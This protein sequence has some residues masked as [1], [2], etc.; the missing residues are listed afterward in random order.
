MQYITMGDKSSPAVLLIHGMLCTGKDNLGFGRYLSD[1]F[2]VISPTL[3]GHGNDGTD[4][5]CVEEEAAKI[6]A[7]LRSEGITSLALI[8]GSSM[9]AE[10]AL[11]VRDRCRKEGIAVGRCFFDGGPFFCFHPIKRYF[12]RLTFRRLVKILNDDPDRAYDRLTKNRLVKFITKD[13][14]SQFEPMLRSI[15]SER[16]TFTNRTVDGMVKVCYD[17]AL[18]DFTEEEQRSMVFFFSLDEPARQSKPRLKKAYP[19]AVYRDVRGYAHCLLQI[20]RPRT[21]A[22]LLKSVIAGDRI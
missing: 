10:V 11:A 6:T 18:P 9:G 7:Y 19:G 12:M 3:D 8:Q 13:K 15:V 17:C 21:Y 2:Y 5:V 1:S 22:R 16:R 14:L 20:K 4:L